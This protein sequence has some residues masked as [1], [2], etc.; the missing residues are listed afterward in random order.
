MKNYQVILLQKQMSKV[1]KLLA[2]LIAFVIILAGIV[3]VFSNTSLPLNSYLD[4][5]S[6]FGNFY[7]SFGNPTNKNLDFGLSNNKVRLHKELHDEV[8]VL[9]CEEENN[10]NCFV[11][12]SLLLL[13]EFPEL[14]NLLLKG[15]LPTNGEVVISESISS[16]LKLDVGDP[17]LLKDF[18]NYAIFNVSG[19]IKDTY[20]FPN[21]YNPNQIYTVIL[22]NTSDNWRSFQPFTIY[23]FHQNAIRHNHA[24]DYSSSIKRIVFALTIMLQIVLFLLFVFMQQLSSYLIGVNRFLKHQ[25]LLGKGKKYLNIFLL[26]YDCLVYSFL[27]IVLFIVFHANNMGIAYWMFILIF[28]FII[29]YL[30]QTK[31]VKKWLY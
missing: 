19:I 6:A 13:P 4:Y 15:N 26:K 3:F 18:L 20:G 29:T 28:T 23:S 17:V 11:S 27:C 25:A 31:R 8:N 9:F 12:S 21:E 24:L 5:D 2:L 10:T 22:E 7:L 14:Q 1:I 30:I 16:L